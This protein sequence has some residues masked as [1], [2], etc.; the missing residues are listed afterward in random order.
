[1]AVDKTAAA[2]YN[3]NPLH[4][5]KVRNEL[6]DMRLTRGTP[7]EKGVKELWEKVDELEAINSPVYGN[8]QGE[9]L[10]RLKKE[11]LYSFLSDSPDYDAVLKDY[12][13]YQYDYLTM[14]DQGVTV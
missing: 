4:K 14:Y 6:N 2:V 3:D 7:Y 9:D 10:D 13:K 8:L 12:E 1:M 5:R 11:I